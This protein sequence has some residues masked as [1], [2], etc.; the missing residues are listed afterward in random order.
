[1]CTFFENH[2]NSMLLIW[3]HQ[4]VYVAQW[5]T[6]KPRA[7][8]ENYLTIC[9]WHEW[10][11]FENVRVTQWEAEAMCTVWKSPHPII[12]MLFLSARACLIA[13]HFFE[14]YMCAVSTDTVSD[15]NPHPT[16]QH[17]WHRSWGATW[18]QLSPA[19]PSPR[20]L[21]RVSRHWHWAKQRKWR[22]K[23]HSKH[24]TSLNFTV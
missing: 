13:T 16:V 7:H 14:S 12:R 2:L 18:V 5:E 24:K 15:P 20:D 23:A 3:M 1:M 17:Q 21:R 10:R 8:F 9:F 11:D 19:V 4:N 22:C 6:Q